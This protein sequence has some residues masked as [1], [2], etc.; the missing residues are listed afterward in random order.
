VICLA[1]MVSSGIVGAAELTRDD[2]AG[3]VEIVE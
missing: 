3:W 2:I 1:M